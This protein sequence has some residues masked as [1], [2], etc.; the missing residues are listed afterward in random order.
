[1][2]TLIACSPILIGWLAVYACRGW[3]GGRSRRQQARCQAQWAR[4]AAALSDLDAELDRTWAAE[5]ERIERS[6]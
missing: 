3:S 2:L 4:I 1:L 6:R 5:K